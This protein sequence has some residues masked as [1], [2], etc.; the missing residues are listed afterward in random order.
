MSDV[1][2]MM[3]AAGKSTAMLARL[4]ATAWAL[5]TGVLQSLMMVVERHASGERL[6]DA[7][8]REVTGH[9]PMAA[10]AGSGNARAAYELIGSVAVV[11]IS[12]VLMKY[13]SMVNGTSQP[14]GTSAEQI[15]A[16]YAQALGDER[17]ASILLRIESPGGAVDGI[18][19]LASEIFAGRSKKPTWAFADGLMASAAYYL[20][21]QASRLI[22]STDGR[23]GSIGVYMGLEDTSA[24]YAAAGVKRHLIK[25]GAMKGIGEPGVPVTEEQLASVQARVNDYGELFRAA[26]ARGRGVAAETV[27]GWAT[28]DVKIG[29]K[30]QQA[31][32]VDAIGTID[33]VIAE[34]NSKFRAGG[35]TAA[36]AVDAPAPARSADMAIG[37]DGAPVQ[38]AGGNV[39]NT[40]AGLAGG[41]GSTLDMATITK[42]ASAA[43]V[44]A[45]AAERNRVNAIEQAAR[46]YAHIAGV[47]AMRAAAVVGSTSVDTFK[48]G[49]MDK[50]TTAQ[51]PIGVT[52]IEVGSDGWAREQEAHEVLFVGKCAP[53]VLQ[54]MKAGGAD[55]DRVAVAM[56]YDDA[57]SFAKIHAAG[58]SAGLG[59]HRLFSLAEHYAKRGRDGI[60]TGRLNFRTDEE[61]LGAAFNHSTSDFPRLLAGG[62]NKVLMAYFALTPTTWSRWCGVDS[63]SD[64]K[65][66]DMITVSELP[67]LALILPG[68]DA[69]EGRVNERYETTQLRTYARGF[70]I[71]RRTIINDDLSG[72]TRVLQGW[73]LTAALL[74]EQLAYAGL[75]N[76][77]ALSDGV[78]LFHATHNNL[79]SATALSHASLVTA[80]T[81]MMTQRGFGQSTSEL[82]VMP[83]TLLVPTALWATAKQVTSSP[84]DP[85]VTNANAEVPS[86]VAGM[87][88]PIQSPYLHRNSTTA[89]YLVGGTEM[90]LVV[91]TFL[92]GRQEP[93]VNPIDG[94]GSILGKR[95]EIIFDCRAKAVQFE[96][97]QRNPGA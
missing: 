80:M 56:G 11:P 57:K 29:I 52:N 2:N 41:A 10:A 30:A 77:A 81:A 70:S 22:A 64:F 75:T 65:T 59:R 93:F 83:K 50:L 25:D 97:G 66:K 33:S 68:Q 71:D 46:P 34:M 91:V 55:A 14:R 94:D 24:R 67:E 9:E 19:E 27:K 31:G 37:N 72:I 32:L 8:V 62:T 26:V 16:A 23:V 20:G 28:G 12:G 54:K 74:P 76:N 79:Q 49:L 95:F 90:P 7:E 58:I 15:K 42:M 85:T 21:S 60:N 47:E 48:A 53:Q 35:K 36:L 51:A 82:M 73:G 44:E 17:V 5:D 40:A 69:E 38:G 6:T 63:S 89:W 3:N 45:M 84:Y 78:A 88:E 92:N 43:V 87:L 1:A 96:S 4:Y 39:Q 18:D 13:S 86:A 61:V